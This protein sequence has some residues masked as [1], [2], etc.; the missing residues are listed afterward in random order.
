MLHI[1]MQRLGMDKLQHTLVRAPHKYN[2]WLV[3]LQGVH[4]TERTRPPPPLPSA[5]AAA[6]GGTV[7]TSFHGLQQLHT[8]WG[9]VLTY[10]FLSPIFDSISK[11]GYSA[12]RFDRRELHQALTLC[13][14]PVLALGGIITP[15]NVQEAADMG[16]AGA[17]VIGSVWQAKDPLRAWERLHQA[18]QEAWGTHTP[19]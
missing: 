12:T 13:P 6:A 9:P 10:A 16:F 7:S 17:A 1:V 3:V 8:D 19:C 2:R 14:F 18:A 11:E 5:A 4:Y 15:D